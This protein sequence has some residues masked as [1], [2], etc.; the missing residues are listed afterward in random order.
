[1]GIS[2]LEAILIFLLFCVL[3]CLGEF[4]SLSRGNKQSKTSKYTFRLHYH[5]YYNMTQPILVG[6]SHFQ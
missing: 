6:S 1:M 2:L 3:L 5:E 4:V